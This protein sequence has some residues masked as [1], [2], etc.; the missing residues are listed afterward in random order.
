MQV[1]LEQAWG[2]RQACWTPLKVEHYLLDAFDKL[3]CA[4]FFF[5][6]FSSWF[7]FSLQCNIPARKSSIPVQQWW[8]TIALLEFVV[9]STVYVRARMRISLNLAEY[10]LFVWRAAGPRRWS[11]PHA[12]TFGW[13]KD[14]CCGSSSSKYEH[15]GAAVHLSVVF[16]FFFSGRCEVN[17]RKWDLWQFVVLVANPALSWSTAHSPCSALPLPE[18]SSHLLSF[19]YQQAHNVLSFCKS[20]VGREI[21]KARTPPPPPPSFLCREPWQTSQIGVKSFVS[22]GLDKA[23]SSVPT[24]VWVSF[25]QHF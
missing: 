19:W 2:R 23:G 7:F 20:V 11:S 15:R 22:L 3:L 16:F 21:Q 13:E 12:A 18:S 9:V 6:S 4:L 1:N 14:D 17:E 8:K 5:F 24:C 25:S 10:R